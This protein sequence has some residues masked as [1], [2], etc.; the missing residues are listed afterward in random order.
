[1]ESK[2]ILNDLNLKW[3]QRLSGFLVLL[4][5]LLLPLVIIRLELL[6]ISTAAL[7]GVIILNR[8]LYAFFL[9]KRGILFVLSCIP[10][11]FLYYFYSA[12]S[13]LYVQ[14]EFRVRGRASLQNSPSGNK[15][16]DELKW[17]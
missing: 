3:G 9:Q 2:N 14:M 4:S 5:C 17:G 8:E 12:L 10:L 13:Y 11:H 15:S 16:A 7:L 6:A 1:M